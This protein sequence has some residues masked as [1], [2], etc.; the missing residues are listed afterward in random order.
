[1]DAATR[2]IME[3][4]MQRLPPRDPDKPM[5]RQRADFEYKVTLHTLLK[6]GYEREDALWWAANMVGCACKRIDATLRR[7]KK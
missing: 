7:N 1:M 6:I 5:C 3:A 4:E 2:K